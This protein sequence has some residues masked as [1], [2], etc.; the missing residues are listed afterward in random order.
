MAF[1]R[2]QRKRGLARQ[3]Q[4]SANFLADV[5]FIISVLLIFGALF[6]C[7]CTWFLFILLFVCFDMFAFI[8]KARVLR[9]CTKAR[10][11]EN[12]L[13]Y[14]CALANDGVLTFNMQKQLHKNNNDNNNNN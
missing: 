7:A 13:F 6:V 14:C 5:F 10:K 4:F 2:A 3:K 1:H 8:S 9:E 12:I 11:K